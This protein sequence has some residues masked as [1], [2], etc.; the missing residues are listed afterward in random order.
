MTTAKDAI[1]AECCLDE[2]R[3]GRLQE[4]LASARL[5]DSGISQR[6]VRDWIAKH[7]GLLGGGKKEDDEKDIQ[8]SK[9]NYIDLAYNSFKEGG[10]PS[11][12]Q[13]LAKTKELLQEALV[14]EKRSGSAATR[15][16]RLVKLEDVTKWLEDRDEEGK[17]HGF[18]EAREHVLAKAYEELSEE[19]NPTSR[20]LLTR[21]RQLLVQS[22][23]KDKVVAPKDA[24]KRANMIKLDFAQEWLDKRREEEREK[25]LPSAKEQVIEQAFNEYHNFG[26]VAKTLEAARAVDKSITRADVAAYKKKY[27]VPLKTHR[28]VN[29]Y[30]AKQPRE[31]YQIDL[32]FFKD[33]DKKST[34]AKYAGALLA[35]DIFTK[36]CAAAPIKDTGEAQVRGVLI[37]CFKRLGGPPKML[38]HDAQSAFTGELIQDYLR[39]TKVQS[40]TTLGHAP[41]AERT[42]RTIKGLLYPRA[43]K[44]GRKWWQELPLVLQL[45]N[46]DKHSATGMTPEEATKKENEG[47]VR[48][49][50]ELNRKQGRRYAPISEGDTVRAYR[51]KQLGQKE[52]DPPWTKQTWQ[53]TGVEKDEQGVP[54]IQVDQS[55]RA[56]PAKKRYLMPHEVL[57]VPK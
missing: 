27:Y 11:P 44:S 4:T 19:G 20:A 46:T 29:S 49:S 48:L 40:I 16:V 56:L 30:V 39:R 53:V 41:V 24:R 8:E 25:P 32:M 43:E 50:L 7:R 42:I 26:N 36:Y 31:E 28:G 45:Y 54:K 23:T 37:E 17:L 9:N 33:L 34:G 6:D 57:K 5:R 1:I 3:P 13:L 47:E 35:V 12:T 14:V 21:A 15:L 18:E 2:G 55:V 52:N 51:K 38:Y 22:Q 10:P